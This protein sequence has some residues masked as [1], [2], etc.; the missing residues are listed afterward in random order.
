[1]ERYDET[2]Y[3]HHI[4]CSAQLQMKKGPPWK[5]G[6]ADPLLLMRFFSERTESYRTLLDIVAAK[7]PPGHIYRGVW[8]YDEATPGAILRI[9]N[10]RKFWGVYFALAEF[11]EALSREAAWVP[12][13]VL[14]TAICK[15]IA[16]G[17]SQA[18]GKAVDA[19]KHSFTVG[20]TI[21]LPTTGATP[22]RANFFINF[23]DEAALKISTDFKGA[24]G[25]LPCMK[26]KNV[27]Y[28]RALRAIV[29][30]D[31]CVGLDCTVFTRFDCRTDQDMWDAIDH[32]MASRV[33]MGV[34]N[35]KEEEKIY[36][37]GCNP[38]G[39]FFNADRKF[40]LPMS[41]LRFEPAHIWFAGVAN[42]EIAN[43]METL[44]S[45]R[46]KITC[47]MVVDWLFLVAARG[48]RYRF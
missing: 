14:R 10:K 46:S 48:R 2:E 22:F 16:G 17:F 42:E 12:V 27:M 30:G 4:A 39:F 11:G 18:I 24:S 13:A 32:L 37:L 15:D 41:T 31:Y 20:V 3:E 34:G 28:N 26:C 47:C 5:L 7:Y 23:A 45:L 36:G 25:V 19:S 6:L 33:T 44:E 35:F 43:I 8:Y 21:V 29:A 1:M 38:H 40:V 9:D